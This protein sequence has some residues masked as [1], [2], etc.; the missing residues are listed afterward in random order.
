M[1]MYIHSPK[2]QVQVYTFVY[3][4]MHLD[5]LHTLFV[6][7]VTCMYSEFINVS[8]THLWLKVY[9][10]IYLHHG[11]RTASVVSLRCNYY[12]YRVYTCI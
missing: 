5:A 8:T 2:V 10:C 4:D 7:H 6:R 12:M 1:C 9:T 11:A 3:G